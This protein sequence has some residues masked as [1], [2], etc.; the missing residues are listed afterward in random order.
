[1]LDFIIRPFW[2]ECD[3]WFQKVELCH[4]RCFTGCEQTI[5][6]ISL[7]RLI[8]IKGIN[9]HFVFISRGQKWNCWLHWQYWIRRFR[10]RKK[11]SNFREIWFIYVIHV[12]ITDCSR[13]AE[14]SSTEAWRHQW[15]HGA[16]QTGE[17]TWWKPGPQTTGNQGQSS[18]RWLES[19]CVTYRQ[20]VCGPRH[21]S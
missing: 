18:Q 13:V 7:K 4:T 14:V 6:A 19:N 3:W 21:A 8:N 12:F 20:T 9:S 2:F 15:K 5:S 1:M 16:I 10:P 11:L 17:Q